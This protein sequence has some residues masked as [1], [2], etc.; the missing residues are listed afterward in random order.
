MTTTKT[1]KRLFHFFFSLQLLRSCVRCARA[2]MMLTARR[3][4]IKHP[5]IS[6]RPFI[7]FVNFSLFFCLS[8]QIKHCTVYFRFSSPFYSLWQFQSFCLF[9]FWASDII[10]SPSVFLYPL[11]VFF[12]TRHTFNVV[13]FYLNFRPS[14]CLSVLIHRSSNYLRLSFL[15]HSHVMFCE[16]AIFH[17]HLSNLVKK[18]EFYCYRVF[19]P[20]SC[21]HQIKDIRNG[22]Q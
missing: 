20:R 6:F 17:L 15:S 1:E 11:A 5:S 13:L 2:S 10:H 22:K 18:D 7:L 12:C 9:V 16:W 8:K 4:N 3:E 21:R 19:Q 14:V